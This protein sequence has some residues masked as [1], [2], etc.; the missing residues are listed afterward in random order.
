MLVSANKA[1][2]QLGVSATTLRSWDSKGLIASVRTPGNIRLYDIGSLK[3]YD[4]NPTGARRV[5]QLFNNG[6]HSGTTKGNRLIYCRVSSRKQQGDL[7]R[8]IAYLAEKYP[9][10]TIIRDIGSG[11]NFKRPGLQ[12]MSGM[13]SLVEFIFEELTSSS[14]IVLGQVVYQG[15]GQG[16][17]YRPPR[18]TRS[19][20]DRASRTSFQHLWC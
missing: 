5:L 13:Q 19:I 14:L 2:K 4:D 11:I 10:R 9:G 7:D 18:Q 8:Q 16:S 3:L 6:E 12:V 20:R 1:T 15:N 17:Y